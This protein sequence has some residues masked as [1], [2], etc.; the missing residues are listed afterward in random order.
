[1]FFQAGNKRK[2]I[3]SWIWILLVSFPMLLLI[4]WLVWW[5]FCPSYKRTEAVEIDAPR[6]DSIPVTLQKDDLSIIKGI[7]PKTADAL[8]EAGIL[9][10]EQ[11]GLM[12]PEQLGQVLKEHSLPVSNAAFWQKQ[13]VLAAAQDWKGLE[14]L[15]K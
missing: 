6:S 7:G 5:F 1:M 8:H 15:Q 9:R 13:A 3:P 4:R 2:L 12:D 11:L 10:F 14:K